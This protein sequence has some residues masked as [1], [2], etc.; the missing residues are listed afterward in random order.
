M[1]EGCGSPPPFFF[2]SPFEPSVT[3]P[4]LR[5]STYW[6][7]SNTAKGQAG[8]GVAKKD[9]SD[10]SQALGPHCPCGLNASLFILIIFE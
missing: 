5:F 2:T 6:S 7:Y 10:V 1:G 8:K 3:T 9:T 4:P